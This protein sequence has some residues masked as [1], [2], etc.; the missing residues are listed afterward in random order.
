M[1]KNMKII[2][3]LLTNFL[4]AS[5]V[6]T[7]VKLPGIF[8]DHMVIQRSQPV[9]VWGWSSPN[10]KIVVKFNQQQKEI[11]A[12]RNGKWRLDLDPEPAGGPYELSV[13]GKNNLIMHDVLV[14]E[15]W[16]CSGQSNMEFQLK[17]VRGA[18]VEINAANYPEIRHIKIALTVSSTPKEDIQPAKW[19]ICSSNT[20]GDFTAVGYFFARELVKRLH[21]PVGLI[22][23][24]WGGT[25][26]EAWTSRGAFEKS[27]EFKSMFASMAGKDIQG[28][29]KERQSGLEA[30][31]KILQKNIHDSIPENE[32]KNP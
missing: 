23:S 9:P 28:L 29:I 3:L 12:D 27:G 22:N 7:Q 26:V 19:N 20:A 5:S 1:L 14:G 16:L 2:L 11:L 6:Y 25:M 8:G 24:T 15:V 17:S 13:E 32:W 31:I 30:Q 18:D 21:V 10:E 4:L